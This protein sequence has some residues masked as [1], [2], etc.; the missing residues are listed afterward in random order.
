MPGLT[1]FI[2]PERKS[3]EALAMTIR[4]AGKAFS[5]F[6]AARLVLQ[7]GDRFHVKFSVPADAAVKLCTIPADGSVWLNR[8]EAVGHF[9][10]S[11]GLKEFYRVEEIELEEPKGVFNSIA[12]CGLTGE[13]LGPTSHHSYQTAL[14][15][16]HRERFSDMRFED[17]K[18]RVRTDNSPEIIEKWKESQK[19]G[20]VWIYLTPSLEEGAEPLK[21][22]TRSEM[23]AHFRKT[24]ADTLV[25]ETHE[26][27][28]AGNIPKQ[29]LSPSLYHALRRGVDDAR[30]HLLPVAQIL[31]S[32]FEGHGLKLF[33]RRGGKL[34]VSRTRPKALDNSVV[35]SPRIARM[36]E[37]VKAKPGITVKDLVEIVS[38][39]VD[40]PKAATPAQPATPVAEPPAVAEVEATDETPVAEIEAPSEGAA[41]E[42][43]EAPAAEAPAPAPA[44][45]AAPAPAIATAPHHE[46]T[47]DQLHVLQDLHWLNSEGYVIEY[48]DGIVFIG[49]TEPPPPKPKAPK[50]TAEASPAA[51]PQAEAAASP[52]PAEAGEEVAAAEAEASAPEVSDTPEESPVGE[53][54]ADEPV[55]EAVESAAPSPAGSATPTDEAEAAEDEPAVAPF[56]FLEDPVPAGEEEKAPGH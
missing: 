35:L 24:H 31:C 12:V 56:S 40:E 38:P 39:S 49:V 48:S 10:H 34:W 43:P 29:H 45:P 30:K 17:Y 16:I 14:H 15:R 41:A 5:V 22:K 32:G 13:V 3:T 1:T 21:F 42:T 54:V 28:V 8:E 26:A 18:R 20:Q 9:L 7:S 19:H 53:V 4:A 55:A 11:E 50:Q 47:S 46:W 27:W 23:E 25:H 52:E 44:I 36:V 37:I 33:K 2:E 6:D 51:Q